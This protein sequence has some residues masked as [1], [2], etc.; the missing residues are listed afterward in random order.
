MTEL[1]QAI[2]HR[3][4]LQLDHARR[5]QAG[6]LR[7]LLLDVVAGQR[8][9]SCPRYGNCED[10]GAVA[11]VALQLA[12]AEVVWRRGSDVGIEAELA[13]RDAGIRNGGFSIRQM[14]GSSR[15]MCAGN[16]GLGEEIGVVEIA[17]VEAD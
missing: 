13:T 16:G 10:R 14:R 5:G 9:R 3:L 17:V 12:E 7:R 11:L 15:T 2:A 4:H 1:E 8:N 6:F